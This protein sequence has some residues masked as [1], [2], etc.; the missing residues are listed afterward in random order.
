MGERSVKEKTVV[1][2]GANSGIGKAATIKFAKEGYRVIMACR[3]ID[4]SREVQQDIIRLTENEIVEL[5]KLD[6]SSFQ[7]IQDFCNQLKERHQKLDIL[8]NNAGHFDHGNKKY[9]LS[10]ENIEIT[11]ATNTFGPM[12]LIKLLIEMLSKSDDPRILNACST[13]IRHFFDSKR[14]IV[15]DNLKGEFKDSRGYNSYKMYG[16]SKMALLM[17]TFKIAKEYKDLGIKVNA[18]QIPA[19]KLSKRTLKN[20]KPGWRI[21]A[22]LENIFAQL[23]ETMGETYYHICTSEDFINVTGRLINDRREI[24]QE[25]NYPQGLISEIKQLLDIK[26]YPKYAGRKDIIEKVWEFGNE[27]IRI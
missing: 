22:V 19:I 1:I 12:L 8:I 17:L 13:N 4:L 18:I 6:V 11:F 16:D 20:L 2:T 27:L 9:Q 25:S 3:N 21:A 10:P 24:T 26:V 14:K 15:F 7:S 23:P 5:M